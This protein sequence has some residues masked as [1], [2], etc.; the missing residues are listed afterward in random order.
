MTSSARSVPAVMTVYNVTKQ[1]SSE[2]R[3]STLSMKTNYIIFRSLQVMH[4]A[5]IGEEESQVIHIVK[6]LKEQG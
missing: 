4:K 6:I 2:A 1:I 5:G 3:R